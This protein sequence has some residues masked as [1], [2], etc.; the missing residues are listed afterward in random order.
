MFENHLDPSQLTPGIL[1]GEARRVFK[2]GACAALAIAIYDKTKWPI[3]AIV[4]QNGSVVHWTVRRPDNKLIDVDGG[5]TQEA[6]IA[7]Y[8]GH[9][10]DGGQAAAI[11]STRDEATKRFYNSQDELTLVNLA[12]TY[13]G[14]VLAQ[15]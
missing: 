12:A 8:T 7:E 13:V 15:A 9:C 2:R 6:L 3:I 1:D 14:P 5:H 10:D 4:D 11:D